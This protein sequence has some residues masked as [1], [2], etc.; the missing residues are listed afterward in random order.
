M[1]TDPFP[2]ADDSSESKT[3]DPQQDLRWLEEIVGPADPRGGL[4]DGADESV[5]QRLLR[6]WTA[7]LD[8]GF[9]LE[10][11]NETLAN[12]TAGRR[13]RGWQL[14]LVGLAGC[15]LL[16]WALWNAR[17]VH[18][19][20]VIAE[21]EADPNVTVKSPVA[22]GVQ[23]PKRDEMDDDVVRSV[24][25]LLNLPPRLVQK[26]LKQADESALQRELQAWLVGW[27]QAGPAERRDLELQW[28][29]NRQFWLIWSMQSLQEMEREEARQSAM[30]L[31]SLDLGSGAKG[32]LERCLTDRRLASLALVHWIPLAEDQQLVAW[33][34]AADR[35]ED[36]RRVLGELIRRDSPLVT[37]T[38]AGI[39]GHSAC[40]VLLGD[41]DQ[42]NPVH[43]QRALEEL[44]QGNPA[45]QYQSALL[46]SVIPDPS[47]DKQ[48]L[49]QIQRGVGIL[50]ATALLILR[51]ENDQ[52]RA[53]EQVAHWPTV[54]PALVSAQ[55]QVRRWN[56][57]AKRNTGVFK[58]EVCERCEEK[59]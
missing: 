24:R 23:L 58:Q 40:R 3:P 46:L 43:R 10:R 28:I 4:E 54:R 42:W 45:R 37:Q 39:A 59:S 32:F 18:K 50:P 41:L 1:N 57:Q 15:L 48:L 12:G 25:Q 13:S 30:E 27:S 7:E 56:L 51:Q 8:D 21:N 20:E 31:I 44:G 17:P 55:Q 53:L 5:R 11:S 34:H 33:L 19:S 47:I 35:C 22:D 16:G 52:G 49:A 38:L 9:S 26:K 14:T 6:V 29:Q 2:P 36:I